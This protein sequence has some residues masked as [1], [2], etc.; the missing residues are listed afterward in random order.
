MRI[1]LQGR[2]W[3]ASFSLFFFSVFILGCAAQAQQVARW[4]LFGGYSYMRLDT[5]ALGFSDYSNT[6]GWNASVTGNLNRRFGIVLDGSGHY[7][8][9]IGAYNIMIGPQITERRDKGKFFAHLLFGKSD[10]HVNIFEPQPFRTEFTGVGLAV[11]AGG[12]FDLYYKKRV[13]F[14]VFQ[15]DYVHTH[16]FGATEQNVRVS[17]GVLINFGTVHR[18]RHR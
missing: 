15:A 5:P 16:S 18:R 13:T 10:D 17:T 8:S 1:R 7:A 4:E 12:G 11:A 2:S 14:R 6:N 9:N 3:P